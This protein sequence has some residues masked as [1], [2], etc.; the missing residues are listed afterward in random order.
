MLAAGPSEAH[1]H[2][3]ALLASQEKPQ[4]CPVA[5]IH[6]LMHMAADRHSYSFEDTTAVHNSADRVAGHNQ[7]DRVV[8]CNQADMAD[9]KAVAADNPAEAAHIGNTAHMHHIHTHIHKDQHKD[10]HKGYT[11]NI[12]ADKAEFPI[13]P[14][15]PVRSCKAPRE[16]AAERQAAGKTEAAIRKQAVGTVGAVEVA[17]NVGAVGA[18]EYAAADAQTPSGFAN[19]PRLN[20]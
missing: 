12:E 1:E 4:E 2:T 6:S 8:D 19:R 16:A 14:H 17:E 9:H 15:F 20:P 18:A 3:I 7:T 5:D 10:I 13:A 11:T